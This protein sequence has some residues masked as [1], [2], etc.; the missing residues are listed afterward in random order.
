MLN[1][2]I[3]DQNVLVGNTN[4]SVRSINVT[5]GELTASSVDGE[6]FGLMF[7]GVKDFNSYGF[8]WKFTSC[9]TY[10]IYVLMIDLL[11]CNIFNTILY[12]FPHAHD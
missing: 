8:F 12:C 10:Y 7:A 5:E 3:F 2:I 9:V 6:R 1:V 11:F 4:Y